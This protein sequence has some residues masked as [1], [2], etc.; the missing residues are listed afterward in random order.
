MKRVGSSW[1]DLSERYG[2]WKTVYQR[3]RRWADDGTWA[4]LKAHVIALAELDHWR[5]FATRYDKLA[6]H[7]PATR[8]LVET[9]DWLRAIPDHQHPR[10]RN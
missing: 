8:D 1:R 10:D 6:T 9:L 2:P 7:S 5:G 4:N 3:F